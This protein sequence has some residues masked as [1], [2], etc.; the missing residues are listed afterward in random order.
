M[1]GS[2]GSELPVGKARARGGEAAADSGVIAICGA[3][4]PS[5]VC[6]FMVVLQDRI[7]MIRQT[8]RIEM[9]INLALTLD[10][11]EGVRGLA[12]DAHTLRHSPYGNPRRILVCI[13]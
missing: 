1:V 3:G 8:R 12:T 4:L 10:K 13:R 7:I 9:A 2:D 6:D 5:L 11:I